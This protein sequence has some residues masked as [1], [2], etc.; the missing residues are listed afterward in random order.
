MD[1]QAGFRSIDIELSDGSTIEA[2]VYFKFS[3]GDDADS[4][5]NE[6]MENLTLADALNPMEGIVRALLSEDN[7]TEDDQTDQDDSIDDDEDEDED[8]E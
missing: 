3:T 8:E 2:E 4:K 6:L 1:I 7:E 5:A